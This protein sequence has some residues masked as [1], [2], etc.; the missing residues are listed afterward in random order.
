MIDLHPGLDVERKEE[1][2]ANSGDVWGL[3]QGRDGAVGC[4][5]SYLS[6][7]TFPQYGYVAVLRDI[8]FKMKVKLY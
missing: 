6:F 5:T 2:N 4:C 8:F 7:M 3:E 1:P